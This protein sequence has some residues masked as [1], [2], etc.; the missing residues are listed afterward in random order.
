MARVWNLEADL[1]SAD[2]LHGIEQGFWTFVDRAGARVYM[3]LYAADGRSYLLELECT[4]YGDEPL[5]GRFVTEDSRQCVAAA[6]PRGNSDT[7][8][9]SN[10]SSSTP[11][12]LRTSKASRSPLCAWTK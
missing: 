4:H 5:L 8:L 12:A 7:G 11:R 6:W 9:S 10:R 1:R 3:R 2:F